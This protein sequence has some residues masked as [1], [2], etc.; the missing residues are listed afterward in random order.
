M[1]ELIINKGIKWID[2]PFPTDTD[3]QYLKNNFDFHPIILDELIH[4]SDRSKTESYDGYIYIVLHL[5]NYNPSMRS[6]QQA[7][8][9][10]L[11]T[12]DTLITTHYENLEALEEFEK[13]FLNEKLKNHITSTGQLVYYLLGEIDKFSFRQLRHIEIKVKKISEQLFKN[14]ER[15]LLEEISFLKRD[16]AALGIITWPQ[17]NILD[18]LI[19]SGTLFWG[20]QM[21]VYFN[22]ALGEHW[23]VI[24][25]LD[26]LKE[27]VVA[28]E[29]TNFQLLNYRISEVIKTITITAFLAL[30]LTVL[31]SILQIK[32]FSVFLE[33]RPNIIWLLLGIVSLTSIGLTIYFKKR[34]WL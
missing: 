8:I 15:K 11:V 12:K 17:R 28:F 4:P 29:E 34:K 6:A 31:V 3:I 30:P 7:E 9:D 20:K 26:N 10:V 14:N 21:K 16:I 27:T 2:I 25:H 22:D 19:N 23:R 32:M 13:I 5:A 33:N 24:H 1:K 18:S